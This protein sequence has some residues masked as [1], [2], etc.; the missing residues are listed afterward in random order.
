MDLRSRLT[1]AWD[2]F[3][4]SGTQ[5]YHNKDL[6][7]S[8][9]MKPDRLRL[10]FGNERSIIASIYTRIAV[11]VAAIDVR[12]VRVD[13]NGTYLETIKS[14][15]N[16]CLNDRANMDQT[17]R[18]FLQDCVMS[19]FDEGCIGIVPV[20]CSNDP[21]ETASYDIYS[22]RTAKILEWY[23]KY[24]RVRLYNEKRGERQD[25]LLPKTMVAI[26]ENPLYAVMNEPNSTLKRLAHKLS[27][28][29]AI[30]DQLGSG[31]LDMIIQLPYV[32][33]SQARRDQ[34][35]KRRKDIEMQ[36]S[37]SK[38][39]IAYT[40]GTEKI[41]QLNRPLENNLMAQIEYLTKTLYG[42]LG[43]TENIFNGTAEE[44]EE[45][46]YYNRTIEP[47]L[48]AIVDAI[49]TTFLS[50]TARTQGQSVM[51]F[52]EP[53]KLLPMSNLSDIADKLI[54]NEILSANEFRAILGYKPNDD[55]KSDELRNPN[56]PQED[57]A[58]AMMEEDMTEED[59]EQAFADLDAVDAELDDLEAS[60][61]LKH[62]ASPYYDPVKAHEYYMKN[63]EL[64]GRRS[65]SS[66]NDEGKAAAK[67]VRER[68]N[69]ERKQKVEAS[70]N[71]MTSNIKTLQTATSNAI[72]TAREKKLANVKAH[73]EQMQTK[74]KSL[75]EKLKGMTSEEKEKNS[76]TIQ[77]EIQK[78][79]DSNK[80]QR[81]KLTED[82]K[83]LSERL[84]TNKKTKSAGYRENHKSNVAKY[85]KEYEDQ[86]DA[87]LERIKADTS[88]KKVKKAKKTSTKKKSTK[89]SSKK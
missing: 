19:L 64:K 2:A 79:R 27:L 37:T 78:L 68:L 58:G 54:R 43:L 34:A 42:Q 72:T 28:L 86:Y 84:Q 38:L 56:M 8:Y 61:G 66:L 70:K 62:Y 57:Q 14:P 55:P 30:D 12:H 1:S 73:T 13:Q 67:Y 49:R 65:T 63:R 77:N 21:R 36:L 32:I 7:F 5:N 18:A 53:F 85:K 22:L 17:G 31:K 88:F 87:E 48:S 40:D 75:R 15:L 82:Y 39:G 44:A 25:I 23:P 26:V 50:Q 52:R 59:F 9:S 81:N 47:I 46:N 20:D 16:D 11:D 76:P 69:D 29:D 24:V 71:S 60:T 35:E 80:V 6:G 3:R 4:A 51:F 33:K 83:K 74:I 41:I 10:N 89:K 45:L